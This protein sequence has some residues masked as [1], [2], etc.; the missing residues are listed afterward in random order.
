MGLG[1]DATGSHGVREGSKRPS[2]SG[3]SERGEQQ[4]GDVRCCEVYGQVH[5]A[6]E[7]MSLCYAMSYDMRHVVSYDMAF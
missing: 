6:A 1:T 3:G 4:G 7:G 5:A 2:G